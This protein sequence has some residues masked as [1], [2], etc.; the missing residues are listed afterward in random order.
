MIFELRDISFSYHTK[1]VLDKI[2]LTVERGEKLA[3]V[4]ASGVGKSTLLN[5]LAQ[6]HPDDIA[7]CTQE[8]NLVT[9]LSCYNNIYLAKLA[10]F[11]ALQNLCNL[12]RPNPQELQRI[13][14]I[15]EQLQIVDKLHHSVETLSGGQQQRVAIARAFYQQ[16]SIFIGDEPV[17]N[18]DS[19]TARL[20]LKAILKRHQSC[21]IALHDRTMALTYFDRVVGLKQG[22]IVIDAKPADISMQVLEQ[23]YL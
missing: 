6:Q 22:K 11:G 23:L 2:N 12:L 19:V 13:S 5:L 14:L 1:R 17:S 20:V 7:Y 8:R 9:G 4:G 3:I 15:A 16:R 21:V 18:L 10:E